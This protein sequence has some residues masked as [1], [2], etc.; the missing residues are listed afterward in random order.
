L[1]LAPIFNTSGKS[2]LKNLSD[3]TFSVETENDMMEVV[4]DGITKWDDVKA[5]IWEEFGSGLR[6]KFVEQ[7]WPE[8][9]QDAQEIWPARGKADLS[10]RRLRYT[11]IRSYVY[12]NGDDDIKCVG[13]KLLNTGFDYITVC[14]LMIFTCL[15]GSSWFDFWDSIYTFGKDVEHMTKVMKRVSDI[16]KTSG[17]H[18]PDWELFVEC[19]GMSGYRNLPFPGFDYESE[20]KHLADAGIEHRWSEDK[21]WFAQYCHDKLYRLPRKWNKK[22]TFLQ[23]LQSDIWLTSGSSS[24]G[25]YIIVIDGVENRIK[26][27]KNMIKDIFTPEELEELCLN[28]KTQE[29]SVVVKN[30]LGKVRLAVSSDVL[31]YFSM[32]YIGY[33]SSKFY[34]DWDSVVSGESVNDQINRLNQMVSQCKD[35]FGMPYDYASFDHQPETHELKSIYSVMAEVGIQNTPDRSTFLTLFHNTLGAFDK[36][37]LYTRANVDDHNVEMTL[38]IRGGLMSGL[39]ITA[40][41]GNGWNKVVTDLNK[42]MLQERGK[43]IRDLTSYIKGDDSSFFSKDASLLQEM[44]LGYRKMNVKGGV[45]KFSI[46]WGRNEFLRTWMA[47]RCYGYAGRIIPGLMQRKP[48]SNTPWSGSMIIDAIYK[49]IHIL[50]RRLPT[51]SKIDTFWKHVSG[52]WCTLHKIPIQAL[53]IPKVHGGLGLGQWNGTDIIEPKII[54]VPKLKVK[55]KNSNG[56]RGDQI[57][58]K[59]EMYNIK[60]NADDAE[61]IAQDQM[62][63]VL[64]SDD[65]PQISRKLRSE[66]KKAVMRASY[67]IKKIKKENLTVFV[68]PMLDVDNTVD[69]SKNKHKSSFGS[70]RREVE[71][72]LELKPMIAKAGTTIKA[73]MKGNYQFVRLWKA[74]Q[75]AKNPHLGEF[76]DWY[77]GNVSLQTYSLNPLL[78]EMYTYQLTYCLRN[79][80]RR[81]RKLTTLLSH[82]S[83]MWEIVLRASSI[84]QRVCQW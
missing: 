9:D 36:A 24:L 73:V 28:H 42:D 50:R 18:L 25:H 83:P 52:I 21:K 26:C 57:R 14:N 78:N 67:T 59:A 27:K 19:S 49:D 51:N 33:C 68:L 38:P 55:I 79:V 64:A 80:S 8:S 12:T 46:M 41:V 74:Y 15:F 34:E 71:Q 45:G 47:E 6:L 11:D 43:D 23:F 53:T 44:E 13:M 31:T 4:T 39:F 7:D 20:V 56:L 29:N 5:M 40:I 22:L 66:W 69:F 63:S 35:K 62:S 77:G 10:L 30:E 81:F 72:L 37:T 76:L 75:L 82:Y 65:L 61:S 48:W 84:Y 17:A 60:L 32:A 70:L 1:S 58:K 16:I 54:Q 3:V 2:E